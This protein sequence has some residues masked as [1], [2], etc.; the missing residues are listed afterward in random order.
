MLIEC[1]LRARPNSGGTAVN[2][3]DTIPALLGQHCGE[4]KRDSRREH[5]TEGKQAKQGD[6]TAV[7]VV[8]T[9]EQGVRKGP[10]KWEQYR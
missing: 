9:L 1:L 3:K 2:K 10:L 8:C 4:G 5:L 7:G 6:V